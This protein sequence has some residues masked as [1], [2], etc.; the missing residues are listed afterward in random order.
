MVESVTTNLRFEL[1]KT[2][3]IFS[4]WSTNERDWLQQNDRNYERLLEECD[5]T[6]GALKENDDELDN[7]KSVQDNIKLKQKQ[8]VAN[9]L[10][11]NELLNQRVAAL[12]SQIVRSEEDEGKESKR[13]NETRIEHDEVHD[14]LE[15]ALN[16]L[17]HGLKHYLNLGLEFMRADGECMKFVF[18]QIDRQDPS[19]PFSFL[20]FVDQ[21]DLY[22]FVET[23][24]AL[25]DSKC[26]MLL[27]RLNTSN[28][29]GCFVVSMRRLFCAQYQK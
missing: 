13:L 18:T 10:A 22:H 15:Q 23:S 5:C 3:Q 9:C 24:P 27:E 28:D 1:E 2:N 25:D 20:M 11:R 8:D 17:S 26:T 12:R 29:I 7:I 6:I 19:R 14:K 16:D 21:Q 4:R